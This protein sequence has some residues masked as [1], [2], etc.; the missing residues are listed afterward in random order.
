ML[1]QTV[2]LTDDRAAEI[3]RAARAAALSSDPRF[4]RV[5]DVSTE[6]DHA[7]LVR[8]WVFGTNLA[9]LLADGPLPPDQAGLLGCE[10][11][12]AISAAHT[13][14]LAHR[15][16]DP[17]AV[18]VSHDGAV[19]IA[20]LATAAAVQGMDAG[21]ATHEDTIG[22]GRILYAALTGR[23]PDGSAFGLPG[24]P[25]VEGHLAS[26]RQVR[27]GVPRP[28]D[29]VVD[30]ILGEPPRHGTEPIRTPAQAAA[31]LAGVLPAAPPFGMRKLA[32]R[33]APDYDT[34]PALLTTPARMSRD[35]ASDTSVMAPVRHTEIPAGRSWSRLLGVASVAAFLL[36][37]VLIGLQLLAT[38]DEP[39][40]TE[41]AT[42][43]AT[44]TPEML[45]IDRAIAYDPLGDGQESDRKA[46]E[47]IDDDAD[48]A[49]PTQ[50]YYDPLELQ[51]AG[52]GLVL[53][54][55]QPND[56]E[57]V[58]LTL[59][60]PGGSFELRV[61]PPDS[62]DVPSRPED[63]LVVSE[64]SDP[65]EQ[66]VAVLENPV[67]TRYVLVWFTTLPQVGASEWRA[68]VAEVQVLR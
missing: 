39:A 14:G 37:V 54:L 34:P 31:A 10:V 55:G 23:W 48:T 38:G 41:T 5:L 22:I 66:V 18:L 62:E 16:L 50:T 52:V 43:A 17:E 49:W 65:A 44:S 35:E 26:P 19:K 63:W 32:V 56:V 33:R 47:A 40:P 12:E 67:R 6:A 7:Y 42:P 25:R 57:E 46:L 4:L 20:G 9:T 8:E 64:H 45:V 29:D 28:L 60:E 21:D 58:R 36:A 1:V 13:Q 27:A 24:A 61:A 53:D 68:A 59:Q 3:G 51:K 2:P 15:R 11:A 30:R